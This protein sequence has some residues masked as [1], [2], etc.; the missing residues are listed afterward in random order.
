[1][2]SSQNSFQ[3]LNYPSIHYSSS[4]SFLVI[5]ISL[6]R[7]NGNGNDNATPEDLITFTEETFNEKLHFLCNGNCVCQRKGKHFTASREF[8]NFW[9]SVKY[10]KCLIYVITQ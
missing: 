8:L 3:N 2:K 10:A 9:F 4:L 7:E 5:F 6:V 1:M